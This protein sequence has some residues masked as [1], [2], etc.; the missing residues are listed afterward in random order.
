MLFPRNGRVSVDKLNTYVAGQPVHDPE[1]GFLT[2]EDG[3]QH[4]ILCDLSS[5]VISAIKTR[6]ACGAFEMIA[7]QWGQRYKQDLNAA[8]A[9]K[10]FQSL[11]EEPSK[12]QRKWVTLVIAWKMPPE[13]GGA[14]ART[15]S[16]NQLVTDF[17]L[18]DQ[19]ISLNGLVSVANYETWC[20]PDLVLWRDTSLPYQRVDLERQD[21]EANNV[22]WHTRLFELIRTCCHEVAHV[23]VTYLCM[24]YQ[25]HLGRLGCTTPDTLKTKYSK[26]KG[27]EAGEV[28]EEVFFG[29]C[30]LSM[31]DGSNRNPIYMA[32]SLPPYTQ[33]TLADR[34]LM[35]FSDRNPWHPQ[36]RW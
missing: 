16:I 13:I 12:D 19:Y 29:G 15:S 5:R 26:I 10:K 6:R 34:C 4:D 18:D 35:F 33:L 20:T 2:K 11:L 9:A 7:G 25:V 30:S 8:D 32:S 17:W 27:G 23:F 36:R 1:F 3:P 24:T 21:V 22:E 28:F 31:D 14:H